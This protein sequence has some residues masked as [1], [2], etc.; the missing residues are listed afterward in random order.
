MAM[1]EQIKIWAT[2]I[3]LLVRA[4][5][6]RDDALANVPED[7]RS[8]VLQHIEGE[9]KESSK[10]P[11]SLDAEPGRR[12]VWGSHKTSV[13]AH[14]S[15]L[16]NFLS[17]ENRNL[18]DLGRLDVAS[19]EVLF[20]IGSPRNGEDFRV[21]GLV[22]GY[23]QSG[24]TANYTALAAKAYDAGYRLV[25]VLS[26]IH[27]SLRHQTQLRMQRE[28]GIQSGLPKGI[29]HVLQTSFGEDL[30]S[31][32]TRLDAKG[33]DFLSGTIGS[34][35]LSSGKYLIVT[36]KNVSVLKKLHAWLGEGGTLGIPT[37]VIDDE[38]DQASVNI[39]EDRPDEPENDSLEEFVDYFQGESDGD[40]EDIEPSKINASI[41]RLLN[42]FSRVSYVAYT[43]T[44]YANVFMDDDAFD[45][46]ALGDLYPRHFIMALPKPRGYVGSQELFGS[47]IETE[48][49]TNKVVRIVEEEDEI[50][51]KDF[52]RRLPESLVSA[53][54][55]FL[56]GAAIKEQRQ[57]G[58]PASMLVHVSHRTHIQNDV[59]ELVGDLLLKMRQSFLWN[60]DDIRPAWS[61]RF[62]AFTERDTNLANTSFSSIEDSLEEILHRGIPLRLMNT[63]SKDELD[64]DRNPSLRAV[65]VGGNKLSRGLTLEGLLVSYFVRSSKYADTITQMGRFFGFRDGY[66][67]LTRIY[68][69]DKLLETFREIS[70]AEVSLRQEVALYERAGATPR[71]FSPRVARMAGVLPTSPIKSRN[72]EDASPTYSGELV[73][74]VTYPHGAEIHHDNS[75]N[76]HDFVTRLTSKNTPRITGGRALWEGVQS[77]QIVEFLK[78]FSVGEEGRRFV[79]SKLSAY[80]RRMNSAGELLVWDVAVIGT[81]NNTHFPVDGLLESL[82]FFPV[83]R[84]LDADS[85]ISIGALVNPVSRKSRG[86]DEMIGLSEEQIA[87]ALSL[88]E[89]DDS[90]GF[91][92]ALRRSRKADK[93]LLL[94][95]PIS[96]HSKGTTSG[97]DKRSIGSVLFGEDHS[98][99]E[100][101]YGLAVSFPASI[102]DEAK[103]YLV[104]PT[105]R[106]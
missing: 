14:W 47:D 33:G 59:A 67:D 71:D 15:A 29:A 102:S 78:T 83:S 32:L 8:A 105:G 56:F 101:I 49:L 106:K 75:V 60:R 16:Y 89:S 100:V 50:V 84:S 103:G 52:V 36:K 97:K 94:I 31:P 23:V 65:V 37:L 46:E 57:P 18:G 90:I 39:G 63:S 76:V 43:A 72:A 73:Q 45:R 70:E 2:A 21:Q 34:E 62:A 81:E 80:V 10:K 40:L 44:P 7:F 24:K 48:A 95:Y 77:T 64:Y 13:G 86:G 74:M 58:S 12:K 5:A 87:W 27:N 88:C 92:K 51:F 4:G 11:N 19:D 61:A 104:G 69:T 35:I 93:G 42:R 66:L 91:G 1:N 20:R 99:L 41:R 38:A 85:N 28:L 96:A 68:T 79:P 3:E 9:S 55:D 53:T 17:S 26:G 98:E 30:V 25:I 6:T 22:I 82:G 54:Y